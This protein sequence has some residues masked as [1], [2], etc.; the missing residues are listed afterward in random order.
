MMR[1]SDSGEFQH[2]NSRALRRDRLCDT[3]A[4]RLCL[5]EYV[6]DHDRIR[7]GNIDPFAAGLHCGKVIREGLC[8]LILI[9]D[10]KSA[11]AVRKAPQ[12]VLIGNGDPAVRAFRRLCI[13]KRGVRPLRTAL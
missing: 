6:V 2:E 13:R 5:I 9:V 8:V 11:A 10:D 4:E 7:G 3:A 12:T 1:L